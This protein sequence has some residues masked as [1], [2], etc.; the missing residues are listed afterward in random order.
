M[1]VLTAGWSDGGLQKERLQKGPGVFSID[2]TVRN[3]YATAP[4]DEGA[5][6][7]TK[8]DG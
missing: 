7:R 2:E 3:W 5:R 1:K 8:D 4:G 6:G